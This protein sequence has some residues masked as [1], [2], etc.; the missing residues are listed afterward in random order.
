MGLER[1]NKVERSDKF[2]DAKKLTEL[3]K[4]LGEDEQLAVLDMVN[5]ARVLAR[6]KAANP[7]RP[8]P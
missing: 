3:L 7:R 2:R 5:A 6:K 8:R 4:K 1:V